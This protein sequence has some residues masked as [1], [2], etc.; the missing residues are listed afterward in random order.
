MRGFG[1]TNCIFGIA[2]PLYFFC[3]ETCHGAL[4]YGYYLPSSEPLVWSFVYWPLHSGGHVPHS[5]L[6]APSQMQFA[7]FLTA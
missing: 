5:I 7:L 4:K 2:F 3:W 1:E 6:R